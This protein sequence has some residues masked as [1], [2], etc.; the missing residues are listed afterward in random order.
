MSLMSLSTWFYWQPSK[1]CLSTLVFDFWKLGTGTLDWGLSTMYTERDWVGPSPTMGITVKCG[2][3]LQT[4]RPADRMQH[5]H[6]RGYDLLL[7]L[8]FHKT[9]TCHLEFCSSF[10]LLKPCL[11]SAARPY[12]NCTPCTIF[13]MMIMDRGKVAKYQ[14]EREWLLS[15]FLSCHFMERLWC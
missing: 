7:P 4:C 8:C 14:L 5:Q 11:W 13:A 2:P 12:F 15:Q 10:G 6:A 3:S 1:F 9:E